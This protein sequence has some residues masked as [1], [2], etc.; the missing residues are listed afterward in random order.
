MENIVILHLIM[1]QVFGKKETTARKQKLQ[2]FLPQGAFHHKG[3]PFIGQLVPQPSSIGKIGFHAREEHCFTGLFRP[4]YAIF[5]KRLHFISHGRNARSKYHR[6]HPECQG[7]YPDIGIRIP[8][9]HPQ[10]LGGLFH[11]VI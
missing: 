5:H 8:F 1:G 3:Q 9:I 7:V 4:F 2:S 10:L 6:I 11:I